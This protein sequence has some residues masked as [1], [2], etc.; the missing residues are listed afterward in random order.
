MKCLHCWCRNLG[1]SRVIGPL[2]G[3]NGASKDNQSRIVRVL[4]R[5]NKLSLPSLVLRLQPP[6][7]NVTPIIHIE[8]MVSK[9]YLTY[10]QDVA[11]SL[12][13]MDLE[14]DGIL[15]VENAISFWVVSSNEA[16]RLAHNANLLSRNRGLNN[17]RAPLI[18]FHS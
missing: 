1:Q 9:S 5:S 17:Q 18:C 12:E 7:S 13:Y 15:E 2:F 3:I 6:S 8:I 14:M 16:I 11:P 10:P 4:S